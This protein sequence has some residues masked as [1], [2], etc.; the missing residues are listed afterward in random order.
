MASIRLENISK[1][2]KNTVALENVSLMIEGGEL[3][4]QARERQHCLGS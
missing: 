3:D 2:F 4:R 1:K